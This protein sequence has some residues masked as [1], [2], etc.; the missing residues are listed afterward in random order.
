V[1]TNVEQALQTALRS[2]EKANPETLSG[3]FGDA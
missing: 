3:I 1:P 2:V